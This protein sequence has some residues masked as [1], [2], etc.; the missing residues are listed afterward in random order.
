MGCA[1]SCISP[2]LLA[3]GHRW[4]LSQAPQ[5]LPTGPASPST[6]GLLLPGASPDLAI[7][8][9][10]P[11]FS[12]LCSGGIHR[13]LVWLTFVPSHM[14]SPGFPPG[15]L[16]SEWTRIDPSLRRPGMP[17][18]VLML[19]AAAS[20]IPKAQ[21]VCLWRLRCQ[22]RALPYAVLV[23]FLPEYSRTC[24]PVRGC[25]PWVSAFQFHQLALSP[26]F[27]WVIGLCLC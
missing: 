27:L 22:P 19:P 20:S 16:G 25:D 6:S 14:Q 24:A 26:S 10:R 7:R 8:R 5:M 17:Q 9:W 11:A 15:A 13:A 12:A 18:W 21:G 23:P 4:G 1:R 3:P 2:A